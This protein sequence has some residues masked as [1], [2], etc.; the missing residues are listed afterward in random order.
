MRAHHF[1]LAV[2][3][4]ILFSTGVALA[5]Q[6]YDSDISDENLLLSGASLEDCGGFIE[7]CGCGDCCGD[8]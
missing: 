3:I 2:G 1:L 5:R 6:S 7:D 4:S 8:F